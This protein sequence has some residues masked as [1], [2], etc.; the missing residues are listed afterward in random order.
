MPIN[1]VAGIARALIA[2][3]SISSPWLG[4]SVLEIAAL[5][6]RL[7]GAGTEATR[8]LRAPLTGIY[9]DDVYDPSPAAR[10]G[11]RV[12]DFLVALDGNRLFSVLDFQ[13]WL[14]LS[15]IGREVRLSL[16]RDGE[17]LELE[18]TIETRPPAATPR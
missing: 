2:E 9:I 15:G 11:V 14:Y 1:I 3:R 7:R 6:A 12:G 13:K 17:T 10:A 5:R 16:F 4:F 18:A 8:T